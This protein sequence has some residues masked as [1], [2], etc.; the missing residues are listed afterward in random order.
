MSQPR[1][2]EARPS[3][4]GKCDISSSALHSRVFG[5]L[6][7]TAIAYGWD[8][9]DEVLLSEGVLRVPQEAT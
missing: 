3:L 7:G 2:K 1:R 6:A 9:S 8:G 4:L 5:T